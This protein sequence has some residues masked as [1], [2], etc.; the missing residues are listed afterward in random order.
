MFSKNTLVCLLLLSQFDWNSTHLVNISNFLRHRMHDSRMVFK[1]K[2]PKRWC[3][4]LK[5]VHWPFPSP[6]RQPFEGC[7]AQIRQPI[8]IP[9]YNASS[10]VATGGATH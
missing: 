6:P 3:V 7:F 1:T 10:M 9:S 4:V 2:A 5:V 8:P